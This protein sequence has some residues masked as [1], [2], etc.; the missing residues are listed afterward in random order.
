ME[1]EIGKRKLKV[2]NLEKVFYPKIGFTKADVIDYYV[3]I[4]PVLLP[5]LKDRPITLKRYPEGVEG[6]HFYQ[7]EAP[8]HRPD[9][10]KTAPVKVKERTINFVLL[11][12]LPSLVWA[13]NI[14]DIELHPLLSR[15]QD[16][17][18]PT[19]IA[20]DLDPGAPADVRDCARVALR[21]REMFAGWGLDC[22]GKTSGSKG[23]QVY[24]PLNTRVTFDETKEFSH[25]VARRL[26]AETP[27]R[28]TSNM[29][30]TLRTGKVFVDWSQN[31][32]HKTTVS[33][34]SL[35]AKERPTVSTPMTWEE[36]ETGAASNKLEAFV[37]Q[38]GD[39]LE[40]VQ[41]VG[42]VFEKVLTQ[43]QELPR[44]DDR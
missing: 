35:R 38:T 31:T 17:T 1:L 37:F 6:E 2:S 24:V 20:F 39:T 33:V 28:V 36:I 9:W 3:Q 16:T 22:Y 10:V 4:S 44:L 26:E 43:K 30:K 15:W 27:K 21:L 34:Y 32:D 40:R 41:Q 42:D 12:D 7:K 29:S 19:S 11:N 18:Q 13:A 8:G 14:A 25:Y 5:H 23:F